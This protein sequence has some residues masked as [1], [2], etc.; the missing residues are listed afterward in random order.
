[1]E[2]IS[3][4]QNIVKKVSLLSIIGN[5][6]LVIIKLIVGMFSSSQSMVADALHSIEDMMSSIVSYIAIKISSRPSDKEHPYG[7][8]KVEYTFSFLIS[9]I[10]II[11]S[12]TMIKETISNIFYGVRMTFNIWMVLVCIITIVIKSG[13]YIYS[14]RKYKLTNNILI[15]AGKDDHRNDIFITSTVLI[16]TFASV[17]G[18][19]FVDYI[20][21]IIISLFIA[22]V[23]IRIFRLSYMVLID[24]NLCDEKLEDIISKVNEYDEIKK[25]D[26]VIGKPIGEKYVI[27]LKVAMN[28]D[29]D[30]YNSHDIE[31]AIK[32]KLTLENDYI[33]DVVIHVNPY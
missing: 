20:F 10:M 22:F 4:K 11:V 29:L 17:F 6:F 9:I 14:N 27:I 18:L 16:S 31:S 15:R 8:G 32:K 19:Y 30:I 13:L 2:P 12:I 26:M 21:G 3:K 25:V 24:T 1:M 28:K 33:Q 23:G 7:Y 5:L